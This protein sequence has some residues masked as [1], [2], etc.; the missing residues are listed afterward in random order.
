MFPAF[1]PAG[2]TGGGLEWARGWRNNG[3]WG[4]KHK[5]RQGSWRSLAFILA[6]AGI[7]M[8][9]SSWAGF[10]CGWGLAETPAWIPGPA[11]E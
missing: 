11:R 2:M 10:G 9:L 7:P 1:S 6:K 5:G 4:W 8:L 3:E